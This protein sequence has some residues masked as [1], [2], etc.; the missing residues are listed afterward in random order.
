MGKIAQEITYIS[1]WLYVS[2]AYNCM[3]SKLINY[4]AFV[5]IIGQIFELDLNKEKHQIL[6]TSLIE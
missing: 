4:I 5:R 1:L 6:T 2:H 3:E